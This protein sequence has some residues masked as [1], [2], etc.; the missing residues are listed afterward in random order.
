MTD[1]T[2]GNP[3]RADA[4]ALTTARPAAAL[5][6]HWGRGIA[7]SLAFA[8]ASIG[9]V[10]SAAAADLPAFVKAPPV[11]P[12][13][14]WHGITIFGAYDIAGQYESNGA[15]YNGSA[16]SSA[17][18]ISPFNR[19][20]QWVLA[21][22]QS[23]QSFIGVKVDEKITDQLHV[24]ARLE[25]GFNPTTGEISDTLKSMQK[26]NGIPLNQQYVN[27]D[28]PR[29]GQVLNGEAWAGFEE[30]TWGTLH[31]G[32]NNAVSADMLFAYDP[33]S[34]Y[35][36]SLFGYVGILGGGGSSETVRVD[37][38]I[39]YLNKWGPI[40][41]EAMYGNPNTNTKEFY[42]GS[43]GLVDL[44]YSVDVVAGHAS[45]LV[46]SSA[47]AGP[48]NLGSQFLGARVSDADT[49]GV[50]GKYVF[51]L[52][53]NGLRDPNESRFT[54][55]G[56]VSRIEFSNPSDG[57]WA[58]G[59]TTIG[60]YQIG[61]AFATNGSSAA[62]I[63][64][65]AYTGGNRVLIASF[66]AGKYQ[67]DAQWSAALAYYR[68]DQKSYGLGVN[69]LPG[70]VAPSFSTQACSSSSYINCAGGEQV[71]SF[72]VDYDWTKNLKLY[73]GLAYSKVDGGFAFSYLK[74]SEFAPTVGMRLTF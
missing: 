3:Q 61:P 27:G 35:G 8:A 53:R 65:Y 14:T 36:F 29:A 42:Q 2:S 45:D 47:L 60:G 55:S 26:A 34:S 62:G 22:N 50:F 9:L 59:H 58:P 51:D 39:K 17:G 48:A 11:M 72:R 71:V 1:G 56:G 24:I 7:R 73:G 4:A 49:V 28:G 25:M 16:Y 46:S 21:P 15:P 18:I 54:L 40:R 52:G 20:P 44:N 38:S 74:T 70:I 63:V 10:A 23:I 30:K 69:G 37:Q 13:L 64:N 66:I 31:V 5:S 41:V 32:R 67:Y 68:Y 12:D 19:G 6:R 57:G 43:I 33:L